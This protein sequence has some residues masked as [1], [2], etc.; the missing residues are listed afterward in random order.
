[1]LDVIIQGCGSMG[2]GMQFCVDNDVS[3]TDIPV[4]GTVYVVSDA[5][6]ALAGTKGAE[7][8]KEIVKQGVVFGTLGDWPPN[9]LRND[10]TGDPLRNDETNEYLY[11]D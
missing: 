7:V 4:P 9:M 1:M 10:V 6:L 5:A 2:A 3:I 8:R 11:A